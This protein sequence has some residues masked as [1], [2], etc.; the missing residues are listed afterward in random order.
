MDLEIEITR[1]LKFP[2]Y[3][4]CF[5]K[6]IFKISCITF[7]TPS[8]QRR[9][10]EPNQRDSRNHPFEA[11]KKEVPRLI[12]GAFKE[13]YDDQGL[14]HYYIL[15]GKAQGGMIEC[16]LCKEWFHLSCLRGAKQQGPGAKNKTKA[17]RSAEKM[18]VTSVAIVVVQDGLVLKRSSR[19]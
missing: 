5:T 6:T 10:L 13:I 9:S 18:A 8:T 2:D 4:F 3:Y 12:V 14:A 15:Q 7:P 11:E 1:Y 16:A 17:M 19:C